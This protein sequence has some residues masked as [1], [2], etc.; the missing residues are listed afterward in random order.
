MDL[1]RS[2]TFPGKGV[3]HF[4]TVDLKAIEALAPDQ[5]SLK[6]AAGLTK[7]AKWSGAGIS[8]DG[9]LIWGSCAGS[10]ANPY[11]VMADLSDLG[12][13]CTCP[14][15]KFPCKHVLA[16]LWMRAEATL[17]FAQGDV[18]DWVSEWLGRR[19]KPSGTAV[20]VAP[21]G[22]KDMQ[23]AL[24]AEPEEPHDPKAIARRAAAAEKR[25]ADTELAL[26]DAVEALEQWIG[27][28]LRLG[29]ATFIDDA[30][31]RCRRIAARLVDGKAQVLAG[32]ID[33]LPSRLLA[34]PVGD[35]VRGA[36]VELGKLV[37]LARAFRADPKNPEIRRS[38]STAE[39]REA[40]LD[41]PEA[42]RVTSLW[43]VLGEKA[44][45]R[46]DGLISQTSW[47]LNLGEAGPRFAVLRDYFPAS[48]GKRGSVFTVGEQ[49]EGELIF[50]PAT[51]PERA[52]MLSKASSDAIRPWPAP[53]AGA[54]AATLSARMADEPWLTEAP[55]LLPPGR[56]MMDD[57]GK[58]W[59][60][61]KAGGDVMP[62]ED[63]AEGPAR[64]S[65]LDC[66][67]AIWSTQGLSL[68]AA[69]TMWGRINC[70]G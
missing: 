56:V 5:S 70:V 46:R 42:L 35:R 27:D 4:M 63:V 29:L 40:L 11:R 25:A 37:M 6:A 3:Q 13:K 33:E 60:Q 61:S 49:F 32:R 30:T 38:I 18:P 19:R 17:G 9:Q 2:G 41:N 36:V 10:G 12:S 66:A 8:A 68:M 16:L 55:L 44:E 53:Q 59:W 15:R 7:P 21:A 20:A 28:Q 22:T 14:S 1:C 65:D 26:H 24:V 47:L 67:A 50:Y 39:G 31:A 54:I 52:L 62:I 57:S 43:E 45:T 64:A 48:A 23:A 69:Q 58:S 51:H 34:L